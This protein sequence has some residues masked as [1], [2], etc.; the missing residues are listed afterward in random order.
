MLLLGAL[1]YFGH[2]WTFDYL[3]EC[4]GI[5]Q[6]THRAFFHIF[7]KFG[8]D[9]LYPKYVKYPSNSEEADAR[10]REYELA[11]MHG[12]IGYMDALHFILEKCSQRLKQNHLGGKS[13]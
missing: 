8:R 1:H 7:V 2:G 5:N 11:G 10:S 6:E 12:E 3:E 4:T 13:K 9:V